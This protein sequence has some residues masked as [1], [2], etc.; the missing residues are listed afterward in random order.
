[1]SFEN[2]QPEFYTG[3]YAEYEAY[4]QSRLGEDAVQKRTKYKKI[5]G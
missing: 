5:S 3:N 4:R 2:E 1:L